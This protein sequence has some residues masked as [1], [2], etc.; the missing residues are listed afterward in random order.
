MAKYLQQTMEVVMFAMEKANT[1]SCE[2]MLVETL[3]LLSI[4][5]SLA[6]KDFS[7]YYNQIMPVLKGLLG[8]MGMATPQ[9][10]NIRAKIVN[11]MGFMIE[12]VCDNREE[13]LMDVIGICKDMATVL[14]M[15]LED[16]DPQAPAIKEALIKS[17]TLLKQEFHQFMPNLLKSL[18]ADAEAD[19]DI[20]LSESELQASKNP[21]FTFKLKGMENEAK[22]T[23]NTSALENKI[24]AVKN[25]A[26]LADSL[27]ESFAPYV[28]T[29]YP[30][31]EKM[32]TYDLSRAIRKNAFKSM[33]AMLR[34][35]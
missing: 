35:L 24:K 5:S 2:P 28:E 25:L 8:S 31:M 34:S 22:I 19:I 23:M 15:G 17:A 11:T 21:G 1:S 12:A 13:F 6:A 29:V 16:D 9:Q 20:K 18:I 32:S 7:H 10:K 3:S 27:E 26:T 14:N 33:S 30:I 4:V